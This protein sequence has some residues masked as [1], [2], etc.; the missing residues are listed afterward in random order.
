M[1]TCGCPGV[2]REALTF[3]LRGR[4]RR[5]R[6]GTAGP[7]LS[8]YPSEVRVSY[9]EPAFT[10]AATTWGFF[11]LQV[12]LPTTRSPGRKKGA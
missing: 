2:R 7:A 5:V 6:K 1:R 10:A 4:D 11:R 9:F 12:S 3:R 8:S